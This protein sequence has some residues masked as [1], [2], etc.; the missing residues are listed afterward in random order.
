MQMGTMAVCFPWPR[1][2]LKT[3]RAHRQAGGLGL[4]FFT[5][6]LFWGHFESRKAETDGLLLTWTSWQLV[7]RALGYLGTELYYIAFWME[8]SSLAKILLLCFKKWK[9]YLEWSREA[10]SWGPFS[11]SRTS[12]QM[13]LGWGLPGS[14]PHQIPFHFKKALTYC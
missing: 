5:L 2:V 1:H 10:A 8:D 3:L 6:I 11:G 7:S 4:L 14:F 9:H 13:K 12:W